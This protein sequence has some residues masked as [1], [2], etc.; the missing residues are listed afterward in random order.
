MTEGIILLDKP[1]G[2][3]SFQSLGE[4]KRKLATSRVGHAGTLD[5]FAEG[6][7]IVLAGRLTRLA[8]YAE[9]MDKE[10]IAVVTF[11]KGTD[12]LDPEG[13]VI[14]HGPVPEAPILAQTLG[15]FV[16]SYAQVPPAYSA[17]H[18]GGQRAYQAARKGV[19]VEIAPRTVT[20][21]RLELLGFQP[22]SA[23]LRIVCS[24]GTYVRSLAR[25]LATR[26]GTCA[27]V[28]GLRRIR[29][30]GFRVEEAAR[31]DRFDPATDLLPPERLFTGGA[32]ISIVTLRENWT[33][34]AGFGSPLCDDAFVTCPDV[35]GTYGAFSP[36]GLLIAVVARDGGRWRYQAV[37]AP[38]GRE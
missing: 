30:G 27:F 1:P 28:S 11:G 9:S 22:P 14:G 4:I 3:T 38:G 31:P 16:G 23:T 36:A 19:A 13:A 35:D 7:L 20:I 10:Y 12:T 21:S 15:E 6:L 17:V 5:R 33:V 8:A 2:Q 37:L 24:K 18:V 26:L 34:K 25:D 32:R 29:I